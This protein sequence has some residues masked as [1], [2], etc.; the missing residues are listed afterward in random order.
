MRGVKAKLLRSHAKVEHLNL[1]R[2]EKLPIPEDEN[3]SLLQ[4]RVVYRVLKKNYKRV[5]REQ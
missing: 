2:E 3:Q 5:M 1:L 4:L